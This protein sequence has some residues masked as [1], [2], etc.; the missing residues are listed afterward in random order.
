MTS[1]T[2]NPFRGQTMRVARPAKSQMEYS[3]LAEAALDEAQ[4]QWDA[5]EAERTEL[6]AL[7]E[8]REEPAIK[9]FENRARVAFL[10]TKGATMQ[11]WLEQRDTILTNLQRGSHPRG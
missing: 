11:M 4:G 2:D 8:T 10:A 3:S 5:A 6:L 7:S 9:A 1:E